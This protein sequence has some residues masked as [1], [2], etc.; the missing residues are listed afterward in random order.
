M[1]YCEPCRLANDW[2]Y[3]YFSRWR[4]NCEMCGKF[5]DD[6]NDVP[7]KALPPAKYSPYAAQGDV[8]PKEKP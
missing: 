3:S 1:F 7:S 5:S 4:G 6:M 8:Q 2:P